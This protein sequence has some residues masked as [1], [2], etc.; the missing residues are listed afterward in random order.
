M[1]DNPPLNTIKILK[2]ENQRL[3]NEARLEC[4]YYTDF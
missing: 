1:P 4:F 2:S 3:K